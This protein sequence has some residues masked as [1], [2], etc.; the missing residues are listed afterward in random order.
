MNSL[1][2]IEKAHPIKGSY[3]KKLINGDDRSKNI[4]IKLKSSV[5][6]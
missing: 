6:Q 1:E 3:N 5:T 4:I 2:N